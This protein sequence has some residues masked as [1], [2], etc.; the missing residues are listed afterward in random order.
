MSDHRSGIALCAM[1]A[2]SLSACG[3]N[4]TTSGTNAKE[5]FLLEDGYV[6]QYTNSEFTELF[7]V[8]Y[9]G[10]R[11]VDGQDVH[12]L[13]WKFDT[14]QNLALDEVEA[15]PALFFMDTYW[16]KTDDGVLF[17]GAGAVDNTADLP[18]WDEVFYGESL[19]FAG[20]DLY[21]GDPA[22]T[23]SSNGENWSSEFV[24]SVDE[25]ETFGGTFMSVM[26]VNF[27]DEAGASPFA[28]DWYL[29]RN[30]GIVQF[31]VH[32]RSDEVWTLNRVSH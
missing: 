3:S 1:A 24:D 21:P 4:I 18:A 29:A 13:S 11:Q 28:G 7:E 17:W 6:W 20:V 10:E 16:S 22:L 31:Q 19:L 9:A 25:L 8:W 2:L 27:A 15:D 32:G 30:T 23:S 5:F 26:Q 12:V 14:A